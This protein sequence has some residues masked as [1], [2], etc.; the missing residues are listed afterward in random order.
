[1]RSLEPVRQVNI[2]V[3][4]GYGLLEFFCAIKDRNGIGN[5]FDTDLPDIDAP[6][7]V[8]VLDIFHWQKPEVRGQK[9]E[10]KN[11]NNRDLFYP[12]I[13]GFRLLVSDQSRY[14]WTAALSSSMFADLTI[15]SSEAHVP[16]S[17]LYSW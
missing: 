12:L 17:S 8:Q 14:L 16:K 4:R 1:M 9:Q 7:I 3:D 11:Q 10:D 5:R 15:Y 6:I 13:S 2:H